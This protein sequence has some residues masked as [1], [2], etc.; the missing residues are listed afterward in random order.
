MT[1]RSASWSSGS[2]PGSGPGTRC[3]LGRRRS[4]RGR[5]GTFR[6][7]EAR[8]PYVAEMGFD[9]LY[10]PPIHPI[11]RAFRKGPNNTPDPRPERPG[12]PLGHRR[13]R[14]GAQGHPPRARARSRTSTAW[15]RRHASWASS[16]RWTSP[17]SARPTIPTSRE[18]P[19]WFRHRPDG[20]IKYA[21]NPPKKYQDIY[22]IDF[23]CDDWKALWAELRD[24]FLFWIGHGVTIFR[25]DNPHTKPF[26]FWDWVI[27]EVWDRHPDDHLPRPRRSPGRR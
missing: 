24:V 2:G 26:R 14:G 16:W 8:L 3:S 23:E 18:H 10:L 5:H 25:V 4:S 15:W 1:G 27:N 9:V 17:S 19:Q 7:V 6:D 13:P 11:G 20:T 21:E 12:Q 22:P